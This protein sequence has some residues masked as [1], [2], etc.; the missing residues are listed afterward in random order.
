M[1]APDHPEIS[2]FSMTTF[3]WPTMWIPR[4]C[5]EQP[6]TYQVPKNEYAVSWQSLNS[7]SGPWMRRPRMR[8]PSPVTRN[9]AYGHSSGRVVEKIRAPGRF[10]LRR[11][12]TDTPLAILRFCRPLRS[13]STPSEIW[14]SVFSVLRAW[15]KSDTRLFEVMNTSEGMPTLTRT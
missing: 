9:W 1:A 7:V 4:V 2:L 12:V 10:D 11:P 3:V 6:V 8:T 5:D 13:S 15:T 14:I